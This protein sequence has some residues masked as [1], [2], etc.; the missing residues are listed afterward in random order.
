MSKARF[1]GYNVYESMRGDHAK[2]NATGRTKKRK[3]KSEHCCWVGCWRVLR[4]NDKYS[5]VA[6]IAVSAGAADDNESDDT[7][8]LG[9]RFGSRRASNPDRAAPRRPKETWH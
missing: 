4:H 9:T 5:N 1:C 7:N 6:A 8:V 3:E 2:D